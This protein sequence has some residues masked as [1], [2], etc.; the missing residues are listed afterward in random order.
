RRFSTRAISPP[1]VPP[2]SVFASLDAS[3]KVEEEC[4]SWYSPSTYYPVR[5]GEIFRSRYQALSK[6]GYGTSATVWLGRDLVEHRYVALKVCIRDYP[7]IPREKAA[8]Q[9]L[10]SVRESPVIQKCWDNF[11]I[12]GVEL[13]ADLAARF[14]N[15]PAP[16]FAKI[17]KHFDTLE[18]AKVKIPTLIEGL[19]CLYALPSRYENIAQMLVQAT[20]ADNMGIGAV[21][22]AVT[23]AW[24]Q[25][26]GKKPEKLG[27]HKI[28]AVKRKPGD[29]SFSSQQQQRPQGSSGN[30]RDGK[31]R[32]YRGKLQHRAPEVI[33]DI[34]FSCPVDIWNVGVLLWHMFE[35]KS[36]YDPYLPDGREALVVHLAQMVAR[37]G[38]P[39]PEL[40]SRS[41]RPTFIE[42]NY[43]EPSG[44]WKGP[45]P[46]PSGMSLESLET[47]LEGEEQAEFLRFIRRC[48]Q[49][50]PGKRATAAEL[51]RDPWVNPV[52]KAS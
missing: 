40:L 41:C 31:R 36:L 3:E 37:M 45:V 16:A 47:R 44:Q 8:F 21:R 1:R 19:I 14:Y 2:S 32:P 35:R 27:A 48:L 4:F 18:A 33:L 34:P 20:S 43:F 50:D 13:G 42:L 10:R 29:P 38:P 28:S 5:I 12:D 51:C 26:Q 52:L 46:V 25:S 7:S 9:R 22:E 49:W 17:S 23:T 24:D 30:A 6:L 15:H 11:K 39:P